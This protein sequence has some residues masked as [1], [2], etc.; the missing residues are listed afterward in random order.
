M[1]D[2]VNGHELLVRE[3]L[4]AVVGGLLRDG[5][6]VLD[7]HVGHVDL[8]GLDV[9]QLGVQG[10]VVQRRAARGYGV[11]KKELSVIGLQTETTDVV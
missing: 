9:K 1:L 3:L 6:V 4:L 2:D 8:V 7:G 10:E 11:V 5:D